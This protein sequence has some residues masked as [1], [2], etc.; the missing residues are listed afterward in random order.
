VYRRLP[1]VA[2]A[3]ASPAGDDEA[4]G[5]GRP[6]AARLKEGFACA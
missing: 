5:G 6:G 4:S 1:D 2:D 3:A